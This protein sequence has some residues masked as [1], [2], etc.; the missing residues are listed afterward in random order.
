M[1]E[2]VGLPRT[3]RRRLHGLRRAEVAALAGISPEYYTRLEQGRQRRPSPEVLDALAT[4]MR[5]DDDGR[6]EVSR[7]AW[8]V[9]DWLASDFIAIP[10]TWEYD[11]MRALADG[12]GDTPVVSGES[13]AGG[14]GVL[15]AAAESEV[16][17]TALGLD[18]NSTVVLFGGEGVT[19]PD[20]YQQTAGSPPGD[21]FA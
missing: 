3:S 2:V 4:A 5:L 12:H 16:L 19:D 7:A 8:K 15:L 17:C 11:G 13:A 10:D 14:M 20:I 18:A 9:L 6:S 1:P 21:V